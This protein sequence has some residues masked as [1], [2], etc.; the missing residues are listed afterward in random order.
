MKRFLPFFLILLL[1]PSVLIGCAKT[2]SIKD[3]SRTSYIEIRA[4]ST[5]DQSYTD[6]VITDYEAVDEICETLHILTLERIK[7]T[8]P[9]HLAYQLLFFDHA[10]REIGGIG[11]VSG[12][13]VDYN[14]DLHKVTSDCDLE[15]YLAGIVSDLTPVIEGGTQ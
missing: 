12:N 10:H 3:L 9:L 13:L 5:T 11:I 14:G 1:L 15:A 4:F 7:I 2:T 6:Y 8:K